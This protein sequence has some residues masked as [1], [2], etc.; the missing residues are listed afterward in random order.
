MARVKNAK[1]RRE[2]FEVK[3]EERKRRKKEKKERK[4]KAND[5][6]D[7]DDNDEVM[8]HAGDIDELKCPETW[9]C[10]IAQGCW[11]EE[12]KC[13]ESWVCEI[14]EKVQ[15]TQSD[16]NPAG[17]EQEVGA[18][19][20]DFDVGL[21]EPTW[22]EM[23]EARSEEI[24]FM[25][26]RGIWEV[27]PT[28][29]CWKRTGKWPT[30]VRWVDVRKSSGLVRS[31]LVARDFKGGDTGRDDLFAATPPLE[32]KRFFVESCGDFGWRS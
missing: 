5:E 24:G 21:L 7:A 2:E 14:E 11:E 28:S 29:E 23:Q 6:A 30:S 15:G 20:V 18:E 17:G 22:A 12:L 26:E 9:V 10:E 4:R 8:R 32:A 25:K 19:E 27:R 16:G 13:L 1:L 31:R 3:E